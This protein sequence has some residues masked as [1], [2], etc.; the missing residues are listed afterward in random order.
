MTIVT[1]FGYT[2]TGLAVFCYWQLGDYADWENGIRLVRFGFYEL[3]WAND[4]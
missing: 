1:L 2:D 4:R 3:V